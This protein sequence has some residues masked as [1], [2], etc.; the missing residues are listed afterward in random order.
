MKALQMR[1]QS[2]AEPAANDPASEVSEASSGGFS[3]YFGLLFRPMDRRSTVFLLLCVASGG[4]WGWRYRVAQIESQNAQADRR[5]AGQIA[6]WEAT[7]DANFDLTVTTIPADEIQYGGVRKD[8]IPAL[9]SPEFVAGEDATHLFP[10]DRVIGVEL[11]GE[12]RAYPIRILNFHEVV[13]DRCGDR[14]LAVTWCPLCDSAA[15]FDRRTALGECEFG[16]SGR[17]YNSNVLMYDRGGDPESLWSQIQAQGVTGPAAG[18]P[19]QGLPHELTTWQS[20]LRRHPQT[21]VLSVNTG[22]TRNY[23]ESPYADYLVDSQS[24]MFPVNRRDDRLPPKTPVLGV[25]TGKSSLA[26]PLTMFRG[27][28]RV[29]QQRIDGRP[30][31]VEYH[32]D[33]NSVRV[34]E[35]ADGIQW[36]SSFWF[37][38]SAMHPETNL[39]TPWPSGE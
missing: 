26:I 2:P 3:R 13:N 12:F 34:T 16:V 14:P 20:W 32:P 1:Q 19:L 36:M 38:W 28:A 37:A 39:V 8:G 22:H 31:T 18:Q 24:L 15:V 7:S 4:V 6:S 29:L 33:S 5:G 17:L 21:S 25:L 27:R 35:A 23:R 9:T 11:G 30:F 10:A